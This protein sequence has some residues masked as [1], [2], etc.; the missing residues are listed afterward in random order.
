MSEHDEEL[1][2]WLMELFAG[3]NERER[4]VLHRRFGIDDPIA[5]MRAAAGE[6]ESTRV[7]VRAIQARFEQGSVDDDGPERAA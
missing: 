1:N 2:A 3:L 7:R 4:K 5:A 6:L